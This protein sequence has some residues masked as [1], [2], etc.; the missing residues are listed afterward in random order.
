MQYIIGN[1]VKKVEDFGILKNCHRDNKIDLGF[2]LQTELRL[3]GEQLMLKLLKPIQ[4]IF[5]KN[6]R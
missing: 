5:N 2:I 3:E 1:N 4:A 6:W